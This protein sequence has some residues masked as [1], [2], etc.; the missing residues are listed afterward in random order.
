ME[1]AKNQS[2]L[3]RGN[4]QVRSRMRIPRE[5]LDHTYRFYVVDAIRR[6]PE[7][8]RENLY[9]KALQ[10]L[11]Q[12]ETS[13]VLA[14]L[15]SS[16]GELLAGELKGKEVTA[17]NRLLT[18]ARRLD[19]GD[20]AYPSIVE[21]NSKFLNEN[22]LIALL[23]ALIFEATKLDPVAIDTYRGQ[24]ALLAAYG[25]RRTQ[26]HKRLGKTLQGLLKQFPVVDEPATKEAADRYVEYRFLDQGSLTD[27]IRRTALAGDSRSD[28]YI[29]RW[30]RKFDQSLGFPPPRRGRPQRE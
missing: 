21:F 16:I 22:G 12:G 1:R 19:S 20:D 30:F 24:D 29:R 23:T 10:E 5:M 2:R 4:L 13:A 26:Q 18:S 9:G 27:Y 3:T 8:D 28:S 11:D 6:H 17:A 14:D 25:P 7:I 15:S